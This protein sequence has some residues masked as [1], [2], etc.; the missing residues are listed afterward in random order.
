MGA[1]L[2]LRAEQHSQV[3]LEKPLQAV[4][5]AGGGVVESDEFGK[6]NG[7]LGSRA[8]RLVSYVHVHVRAVGCGQPR[9]WT[10][11]ARLNGVMVG[12]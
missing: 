7:A 5:V 11:L 2:V 12:G 6:S 10:S 1:V 8:S 4:L 3:Q 9:V